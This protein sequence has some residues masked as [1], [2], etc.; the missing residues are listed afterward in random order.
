MKPVVWITLSSPLALTSWVIASVRFETP[1]K[2]RRLYLKWQ[3]GPTNAAHIKYAAPNAHLTRRCRQRPSPSPTV[4]RCTEITR[5][6]NKT[7][8]RKAKSIV[9]LRCWTAT[10]T[11]WHC[12]GVV[13]TSWNYPTTTPHIWLWYDTGKHHTTHTLH[14][15]TFE[16][17]H[18]F[19]CRP[20]QAIFNFPSI[21][22]LSFEKLAKRTLVT[23]NRNWA[24]PRSLQSCDG[25]KKEST[26]RWMANTRM[27]SRSFALIDSNLKR[28]VFMHWA[29]GQWRCV[30]RSAMKCD[31]VAYFAN[32]VL[33][34]VYAFR[35]CVWNDFHAAFGECK[36]SY[37]WSLIQDVLTVLTLLPISLLCTLMCATRAMSANHSSQFS[38]ISVF[39]TLGARS[40]VQLHRSKHTHT[41]TTLQ[42]SIWF[43]FPV[44]ECPSD[45]R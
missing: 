26:F 13:P 15:H 23:S 11:I 38:V 4:S 43:I 24:S 2:N 7:K 31:C 19:S 27:C 37:F 44:S 16:P 3:N 39:E 28:N 45:R 29:F 33:N 6:I 25:W 18:T 40:T 22:F 36:V 41:H 35:T 10:L 17:E 32:S 34:Y 9:R 1:N 20:S 14:L 8:K 5:V 42:W 30:L 12:T 21:S